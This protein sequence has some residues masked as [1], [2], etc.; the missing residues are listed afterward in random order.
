MN[1]FETVQKEVEDLR[2]ENESLRVRVKEAREIFGVLDSDATQ[3]CVYCGVKG[4]NHAKDCRLDI[5]VK[6]TK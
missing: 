2:K 5:W 6:E 4:F 1:I 3:P